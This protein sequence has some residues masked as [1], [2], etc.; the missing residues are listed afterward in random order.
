MLSFS[1][2]LKKKWRNKPETKIKVNQWR[3]E[4]LS[5]PDVQDLIKKRMFKYNRDP[6]TKERINKKRKYRRRA[7]PQYALKERV[8]SRIRMALKD[9]H[10]VKSHKTV[11]LIGCSYCFF[12]EHLE[13][14]FKD[15]M[16]WD[17]PN[18]FHIDHIRPLASFDL[19]DPEQQ[20]AACH[21][22]NL[23]PLY[24]EENLR[25]GARI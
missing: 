21:Y 22:T 15:G 23:Q 19:T 13:N 6:S 2:K 10:I 12:K 17:R 25:K 1:V 24:P 11:D 16:S 14:Q 4:Y 5:K 20:K 7:D 3:R 9:A 18:S 8:R